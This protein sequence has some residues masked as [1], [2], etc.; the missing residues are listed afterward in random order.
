MTMK[1]MMA[2]CAT[3][4]ILFA[5]NTAFAADNFNKFPTSATQSQQD[6]AY[7]NTNTVRERIV[8]ETPQRVTRI[9]R[10]VQ[11]VTTM[12]TTSANPTTEV[13]RRFNKA[14]TRHV[15]VDRGMPVLFYKDAPTQR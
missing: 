10:V 3:V 8:V 15:T 6:S 5:A 11:P 9:K 14:D 4:S 13:D 12:A 7:V 1:K 2:V